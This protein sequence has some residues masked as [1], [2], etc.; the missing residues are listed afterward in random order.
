MTAAATPTALGGALAIDCP[1]CG[2]RRGSHCS[3]DSRSGVRGVCGARYAAGAADPRAVPSG[4]PAESDADLRERAQATRNA[5]RDARIRE[6]I[7]RHYGRA[8]S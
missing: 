2:A 5:Q 6:N 1:T 7:A 8:A 4:D 3:G